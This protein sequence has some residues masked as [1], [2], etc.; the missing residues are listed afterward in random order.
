MQTSRTPPEQGSVRSID[1]LV[2]VLQTF[3]REHGFSISKRLGT[4]LRIRGEEEI[5]SSYLLFCPGESYTRN[6]RTTYFT[7]CL[8]REQRR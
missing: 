4:R 7:L 6:G 8:S 3:A 2:E 1:E 5:W